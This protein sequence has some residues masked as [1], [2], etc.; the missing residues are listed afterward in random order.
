[1]RF[2]D[3]YEGLRVT[4]SVD[5]NQILDEL[6]RWCDRV[7]SAA[8]SNDPAA[9][10]DA[11]AADLLAARSHDDR[12]DR[13]LLS[14]ISRSV[15]SR[16]AARRF[17]NLDTHAGVFA[18]A[19]RRSSMDRRLL[20]ATRIVRRSADDAHPETPPPDLPGPGLS[21]Q[22]IPGGFTLATDT[23]PANEL[24]IAPPETTAADL[25]RWWNHGRESPP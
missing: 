1:M 13:A 7:R 21:Y 5:W 16:R 6:N 25:I 20:A 18:M 4:G 9:S 17:L 12:P 24:N 11:L 14:W 2:D 15:R 23:D 10:I 22:T 3:P 8:L 19:G